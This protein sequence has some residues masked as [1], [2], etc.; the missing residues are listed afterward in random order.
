[1]LVLASASPRRADLLRGAGREL[2][3]A[4]VDADEGWRAGE[5]P[6]AYTARVARAKAELALPRHPDAVILAADTTVWRPGGPPIGKPGDRAEAA[7]MIGELA[8]G[9][10]LVT[11]AFA[12]VDARGGPPTWL[13][14]QV[15]TEVWMR[16]LAADELAAYLDG[17]DWRGKAGGYGIQSAAAGIVTRIAGSYTAVV[18]LPLAEVLVALRR[19][20]L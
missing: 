19:L 10:H 7:A 9:S 16:T 17:E 15:T 3:V 13:E 8:G 1:M 11:T 6:P 2:V 20:G 14:E 18:G 12:L 5:T 4:A